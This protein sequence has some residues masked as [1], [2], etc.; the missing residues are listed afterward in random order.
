MRR[1]KIFRSF[2]DSVRRSS[3]RRAR[4]VLDVGVSPRT[5]IHT[6]SRSRLQAAPPT[7]A[8]TELVEQ[9]YLSLGST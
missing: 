1:E 5:L 3:A 6:L 7:L 8:E 4:F 9:I 2:R